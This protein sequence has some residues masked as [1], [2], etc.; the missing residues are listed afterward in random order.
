LSRFPRV[1]SGLSGEQAREFIVPLKQLKATVGPAA[2]RHFHGLLK[3]GTEPAIFKA[4]YDLYLDGTGVQA[5]AIFKDLV[6]IGRANEKHLGTP[7]L[8]WAT[9]QTKHAVRSHTHE[10]DMWV[11]EVCDR[12]AYDSNENSEA[13]VFW[14]KWQAPQLIAMTPSRH[15][16]YDPG[17]AWERLDAEASLRLRKAFAED[18]VL[19][20]EVQLDRAAGQLAVKMAQQPNPMQ[21]V[22]AADGSR[23]QNSNRK[24]SS[25]RREARKLETQARR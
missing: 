24:T 16:P 17:M 19:R 15:R 3:E 25:V 13:Q 20:V 4:F 5:L 23:Q 6:E 18:Y 11:T 14:R 22:S 2:T 9:S 1:N 7:P 8:E 21:N 10:I 12:Q